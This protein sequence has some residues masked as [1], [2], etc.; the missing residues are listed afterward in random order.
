MARDN[1]IQMPG[2]FGGLMRYDEEYQ[3]RLKM[4]P[5]QV[6]GFVVVILVLVISLKLFF[7]IG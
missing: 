7:P 4:S 5:T 6:M 1:K 3:S 2:L